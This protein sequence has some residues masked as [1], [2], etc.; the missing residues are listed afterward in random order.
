MSSTAT[1]P[2]PAAAQTLRQ[3]HHWV[4]GHST[5]GTSGRFG[6]VYN[7]ATGHIQ[8]HVALATPAEVDAAATAATA[9]FPAWSSQ[10]PLRRARVLCFFRNDRL[11]VCHPERGEGSAFARVFLS[12]IPEG[13]L[14]LHS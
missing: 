13:N 12:V 7:P 4:D 9:A 6:D 11:I 14:I 8:A 10:P 5:P 3:V 1:L 2:E